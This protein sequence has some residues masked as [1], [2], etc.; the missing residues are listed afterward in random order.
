M[1]INTVIILILALALFFAA[2]GQDSNPQKEMTDEELL[3][4]CDEHEEV[5]CD[6]D[7]RGRIVILPA[8]G[9][10]G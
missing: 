10:K 4:Y 7:I 5:V 9:F 3:Q 6:R 8:E 2:T 1:Q